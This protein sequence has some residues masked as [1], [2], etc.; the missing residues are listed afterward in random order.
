[1]KK[2]NER[3]IGVAEMQELLGGAS[4]SF[5]YGVIKQLNNELKEQGKIVIAGRVSRTYAMQRLAL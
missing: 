2:P 4:K 1:M 5:S 3:F